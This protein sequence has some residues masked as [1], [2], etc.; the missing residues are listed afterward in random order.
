LTKKENLYIILIIS[1]NLPFSLPLDASLDNDDEATA[2]GLQTDHEQGNPLDN[3]L[4][5]SDS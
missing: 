3:L 5:K 4:H 1:T 2:Y